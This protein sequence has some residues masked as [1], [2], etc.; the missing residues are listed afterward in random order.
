MQTQ[1]KL[2]SETPIAVNQSP[3]EEALQRTTLQLPM[4]LVDARSE[5]EIRLSR[6]FIP[7]ESKRDIATQEIIQV[8]DSDPPRYVVV[9]GGV[10]PEHLEVEEVK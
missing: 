3:E 10:M 2:V 1:R 7:F 8:S 5:F 4:C 9:F 6:P